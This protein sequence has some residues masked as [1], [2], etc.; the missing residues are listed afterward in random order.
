MAESS[1]GEIHKTAG[2]IKD[3]IEVEIL[4]SKDRGN[5]RKLGLDEGS[6]L[7]MEHARKL[8][9]A[10]DKFSDVSPGLG[11]VLVQKGVPNQEMG[12]K[13][14]TKEEMN[15]KESSSYRLALSLQSDYVEQFGRQYKIKING[16][17]FGVEGDIEV[18]PDNTPALTKAF[19][20]VAKIGQ[21]LRNK[22]E[23]RRRSNES[24]GVGDDNEYKTADAYAKLEIQMR[25]ALANG[26]K[27]I[28][29]R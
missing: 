3:I 2:M 22:Y 21:D 29:S 12:D 10:M 16:K 18:S 1:N 4:E 8:L 23:I 11:I 26:I 13:P 14:L 25:H 9:D 20:E 7:G 6:T 19:E 15:Y 24:I 17:R 28:N 5:S 27:N